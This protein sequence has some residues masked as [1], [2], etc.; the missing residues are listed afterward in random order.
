M[1][2]TISCTGT[3]Q[4]VGTV[5]V[6]TQ[7]SGTIKKVLVDYN[8]RVEKGQILAEL[9]LDLFQASVDT[10]KADILKAEA[11][12]KKA[13]AVDTSEDS[14]FKAEEL[15]RKIKGGRKQDTPLAQIGHLSPKELLAYETEK[16]TTKAQLLSARAALMS[17][18]TNL[19]NAQIK[20]PIDGVI[21]ERNIEVGQ[22][23]AANYS[24]PTLFI[25]A[26]DLSD[27]EIEA[28]VDESDIGLV[29]KGQQVRFTV[30]SYPDAVFNGTVSRIQL[31]PTETSD[32]V[33]YTV[34]VDAPNKE[35]K[36]LPGMT[37][38]ADFLVEKATN[39]LVVPSA[40]LSFKLD[41]H[42]HADTPCIYILEGGKPKWIPVSTGISSNT[43]TVI[44]NT[45]LVPGVPVIIGRAAHKSKSSGSVLSKIMPGGPQGGPRI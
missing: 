42:P 44:K 20:S 38:T 11:L 19:K 30:Q 37:A 36:L 13:M 5:E 24:T 33:T 28:N 43:G 23:V 31:N 25:I 7:V 34:I 1:E 18:E 14:V 26:E 35:G 45:G 6:G 27:M 39:E 22:T 3:I 2:N 12:H 8:D 10:A 15:Y 32:V 29:K 9:D 17:A 16:K 41:D 40:A 4:A 21:L